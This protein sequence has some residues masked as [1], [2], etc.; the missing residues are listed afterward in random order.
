MVSLILTVN[1]CQNDPGVVI[2]DDIGVAILGFIDLQVGV[3]P[4]ELLSRIDGLREEEKR[5]HSG[6]LYYNIISVN[7]H[8]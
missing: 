1:R 5:K 8:S 7:T 4:G 3:L 6:L 2:G